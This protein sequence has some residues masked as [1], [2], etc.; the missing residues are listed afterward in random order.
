MGGNAPDEGAA[1]A[2]LQFI[3]ALSERGPEGLR[4]HRSYML[5]TEAEQQHTSDWECSDTGT[6]SVS[7]L[8]P[9]PYHP[10]AACH[11]QY[12]TAWEILKVHVSGNEDLILFLN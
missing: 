3:I 5:A 2:E 9:A 12:L 6:V 8:G 7:A 1:T 11:H 10:E 4:C